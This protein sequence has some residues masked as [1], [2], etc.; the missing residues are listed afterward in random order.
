MRHQ[1]SILRQAA[2]SDDSGNTAV[3]EPFVTAYAKIEPVRGIDVI[4]SGQVTT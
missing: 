1:I 4:R 2:S 3:M